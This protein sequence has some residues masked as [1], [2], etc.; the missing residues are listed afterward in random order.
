MLCG[1]YGCTARTVQLLQIQRVGHCWSRA[2]KVVHTVRWVLAGMGL[3][4]FSG[5]PIQEGVLAKYIV[6][7]YILS[8]IVGEVIGSDLLPWTNR[9]ISR[10][11]WLCSGRDFVLSA[12]GA[13]ADIVNY[14]CIY[15]GL[16]HSFSHLSFHPIGPFMW[17]MQVGKG[18]M[19]TL[20]PLRSRPASMAVHPKFPRSVWLSGGLAAWTQASL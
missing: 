7:Q 10:K 3:G 6:Y 17:S 9:D 14:V 16:I 5:Y 4:W 15:A 11:H 2:D 13:P 19:H 12:K 20:V 18:A 8:T 1:L